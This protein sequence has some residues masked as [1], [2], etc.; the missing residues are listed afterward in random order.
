MGTSKKLVKA[1]EKTD[2]LD[3]MLIIS[4]FVFFLLVVLFI[5]QQRIISRSIRIAFWWTR[6][7][8]DFS[9]DKKL[10]GLA[11]V[12]PTLSAVV[13]DSAIL[14]SALS[15]SAVATTLSALP[16]AVKASSLIVDTLSPST[17]LA[18]ERTSTSIY[19][20]ADSSLLTTAIL[21]DAA[22]STPLILPPTHVEL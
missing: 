8:P 2:W 12:A 17:T 16:T 7:L 6:F 14:S 1:L 10:L 4:A 9:E 3:R 19:T 18:T 22:S 5:L 13:S 11:K 20:M 21:S 15:T